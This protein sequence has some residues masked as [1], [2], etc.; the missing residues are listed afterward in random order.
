MSDDYWKKMERRYTSRRDV[1]ATIDLAG[2]QRSASTT[3]ADAPRFTYS[4]MQP[5]C[6]TPKL[7]KEWPP[8]LVLYLPYLHWS[9][10]ADQKDQACALEAFRL[11][12][13][14]QERYLQAI[15][16]PLKRLRSFS[17][18]DAPDAL[19]HHP[20]RTL[21]QYY[22]QSI[23]TETRDG[24][25]IVY[26]W[27][28]KETPT[29]PKVL[30][31]D[32]LWVCVTSFDTIFTFFP[33]NLKENEGDR[34]F[35]D[36]KESLVEGLQS[37][38]TDCQLPCDDALD[39]AAYCLHQAVTAL[40]GHDESNSDVPVMRIFRNTLD[41]TY[42]LAVQAFNDFVE[43]P[44][45]ELGVSHDLKL[46]QKACDIQDEL[47]MLRHL[48]R[49]Q[50]IVIQQFITDIGQLSSAIE[51]VNA[52]NTA[53]LALKRLEEFDA[54]AEKCCN[55]SRS[56]K[57][58]ILV[59]LDLKQKASGLNVALSTADQGRTMMIFTVFT[60]VFLPLSFFAAIYGMNISEWSGVKTN[61][62]ANT[63]L[64][65]MVSISTVVISLALSVAFF[66]WIKKRIKRFWGSEGGT[67]PGMG[68]GRAGGISGGRGRRARGGG[69][70]HAYSRISREAIE[71]R[72]TWRLMRSNSRCNNNRD[73]ELAGMV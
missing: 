29:E 20:R 71:L 41:E 68:P 30:M 2:H 17:L 14:L 27:T 46:Y 38:Q 54:E 18:A 49:E 64:L 11:N 10:E 53:T 66:G 62:N 37:L 58:Y 63:M 6:H 22:Y 45:E 26:H 13:P 36:L 35:A 42:E 60:I 73:E 43:K 61:P 72:N 67:E 5:S 31:V 33:Q 55:S 39:M 57:S 28:K 23:N 21:D 56:T 16:D 4:Y 8:Q 7:A 44:D 40:L 69:D 48:F 3:Y 52:T 12:P 24:D 9:Y 47:Q 59:L 51:G 70:R 34:S 50:H 15:N 19:R 25:Q 32:Q 1:D 65:Y